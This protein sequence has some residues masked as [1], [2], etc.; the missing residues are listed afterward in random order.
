MRHALFCLTEVERL[1]MPWPTVEE[2]PRTQRLLA[3]DLLSVGKM[4]TCRI[5]DMYTGALSTLLL[6]N[7]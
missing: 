1:K 3:M 4:V 7:H 5:M 6:G 2:S